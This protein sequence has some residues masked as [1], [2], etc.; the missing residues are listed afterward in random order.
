MTD[1]AKAPSTDEVVVNQ[2]AQ[3]AVPI[4]SS[5]QGMIMLALK[6]KAD[7]EVLNK[8]MDL[9]ER[10]DAK[11]AKKA[12]VEAMSAFK[13]DAPAVIQKDAHVNFSTAKGNTSY[14]HATL[15]NIIIQITSMLSKHGLSA[16]WETHQADAHVKVTCHVTHSQGHRESTSLNGPLDDSGSKNKIQQV[17]STV[18]YLQR[19]T[20]LA[21]LGLATMDQD[22]DGS[23]GSK[24]APFKE[25]KAASRP[26]SK[27]TPKADVSEQEGPQRMKPDTTPEQEEK[28]EN[29]ASNPQERGDDE[30]NAIISEA[31]G[32]R[33]YAICKSN[34]VAI[35]A[36][37]EYLKSEYDLD[38]MKTI[39]RDQYD[40]ICAW[41]EAGGQEPPA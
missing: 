12:Y 28:K 19:Y 26:R 3:V 17:G 22:G 30:E 39:Y 10:W 9:Q 25:P 38:S 5:P 1:K 8:L 34:G 11:E 37:K 14:S 7:P 41:A 16:S 29:P 24:A 36:I 23:Q 27:T 4:D 18:T 2:Q 15:G 20:L 35:E 33:L 21:A 32:K 13:Q 40:T 31:Q 6:E